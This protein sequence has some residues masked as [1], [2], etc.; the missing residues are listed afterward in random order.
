MP[1][2]TAHS[3]K[4]EDGFFANKRI[5][6]ACTGVQWG[7]T[8]LGAVRMKLR[9]HKYRSRDDAFIVAA[10]TY[11]ILQQS[12]LPAFLEKMRGCGEYN[13]SDAVFKMH[14]GG[15]CYMR[16]ATEPDSIVG[17]RKVR[18]IWLDEAG[19]MSLYFWET[20]Q[21]R[22][23]PLQADIDL[24]TTPYSMNWVYKELIRGVEKKVRDDIFLVRATSRENPY[25]SAEEYDR[26]KKTMDPRRF[27]ALFGGE[28]NRSEGLVYPFDEDENQCEPFDLPVGTEFVASVDWGFTHPFVIQVRGIT[29]DGRHYQVSEICKSGYTLPMIIKAA[30]ALKQVWGIKRFYCGPDQPGSIMEFN[31]NGLTAIP[32]NND[33]RLGIDLHYELIITRK[34]KIFRGTSPHSLDEYETYHWPEPKDLGPDQNSAKDAPVKQF[35]DCMDASR[36]L[37]SMTFRTTSNSAKLKP[38]SPEDKS[39]YRSPAPYTGVV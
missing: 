25:F 9:M 24:T 3:K 34:F 19:K 22:A 17:I 7:K 28:F 6:L 1:V 30:A 15:T 10:P 37:T 38:K 5:L 2:I 20:A 33:I 39:R 12:T 11:K 4:Q 27:A 18:G 16:T 21:A 35:D 8:E 14:Q 23:A 31:R 32:A 36:Y 29:P 26:R 13:K